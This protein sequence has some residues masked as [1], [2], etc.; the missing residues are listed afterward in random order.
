MSSL[1]IEASV[2][3]GSTDITSLFTSVLVLLR[4]LQSSLLC[5]LGPNLPE[6]LDR[7]GSLGP[8]SCLHCNLNSSTCKMRV[9]F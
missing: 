1:S 4:T 7:L 8:D 5:L 2:W 9:I 6:S 3:G